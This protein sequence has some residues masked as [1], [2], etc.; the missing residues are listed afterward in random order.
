MSSLVFIVVLLSRVSSLE[1]HT[2]SHKKGTQSSF[3]KKFYS[4]CNSATSRL[5]RRSIT[6]KQSPKELYYNYASYYY[7]PKASTPPVADNTKG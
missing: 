7:T 3:D 2:Q 1:S 4:E 5:Q 6:A